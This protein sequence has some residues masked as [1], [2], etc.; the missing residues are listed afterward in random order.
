LALFAFAFCP[1]MSDSREYPVR[2]IVGV[3]VVVQ[4]GDAVLLIQRGQEPGRGAWGLPGGAAEL[5]EHLQD[6]AAREIREECEI[7]IEVGAVIEAFDLILRDEDGRVQ[8]HYVIID[9]AARY[10]SGDL[11]AASDVMDARWVAVGE[12]S[13]YPLN[14]KTREV[15]EKS[16]RHRTTQKYTEELE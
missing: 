14:E 4:K 7:E 15:I 13:R 9:F 2:P 10:T 6:A 11:H 3:G 8:Y 16:I 1:I 12:L 5:G